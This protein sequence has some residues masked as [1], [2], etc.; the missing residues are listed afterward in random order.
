MRCTTVNC[1]CW[2]ASYLLHD[3]VD[4]AVLGVDLVAHVQGHVAQVT[5]DAAHLLQVLVHLIFSGIVCYPE[6]KYTKADVNTAASAE[7]HSLH[8]LCRP[9]SVKVVKS[10]S[11]TF[12]LRPVSCL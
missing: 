11:S 9:G 1:G 8:I 5:D 12:H 3:P 4:L 7:T 10:L 6:N 2:P